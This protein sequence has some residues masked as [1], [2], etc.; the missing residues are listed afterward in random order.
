MISRGNDLDSS[1]DDAHEKQIPGAFMRSSVSSFPYSACGRAAG[2]FMARASSTY[3]PSQDPYCASSNHSGSACRLQ[4]IHLI[5]PL[6]ELQHVIP[7]WFMLGFSGATHHMLSDAIFVDHL[8]D[9]YMA[10][11]W[12]DASTSRSL[13]I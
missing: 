7:E 2:G 6:K 13:G 1:E 5:D 8:R 9:K 3:V 10:V 12:G 11:S 4:V